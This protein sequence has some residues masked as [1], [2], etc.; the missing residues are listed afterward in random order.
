M[1]V[2]L[3]QEMVGPIKKFY[4][5]GLGKSKTQIRLNTRRPKLSKT[6]LIKTP[7]SF[8]HVIISVASQLDTEINLSIP[9]QMNF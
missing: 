2:K 4:G 8:T 7:M 6:S 1:D 9:N 3:V 5:Q